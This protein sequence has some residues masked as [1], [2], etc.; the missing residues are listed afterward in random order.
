MKW[1]ISIPAWG[2]RGVDSLI[3]ICLPSVLAAEWPA[4][5]EGPPRFIVHT[6][7]ANEIAA[8][9]RGL[10]VDYRAIRAGEKYQML[11]WCHADALAVAA[12]G[13]AVMTLCADMI[14][15]REVFTACQSRF[16]SGKRAVVVGSSRTLAPDAP[17]GLPSGELLDWM[18]T[19]AHPYTQ[20]SFWGGSAMPPSTFYFREGTAIVMRGFHLHPLAVVL[21]RAVPFKGTLD[22]D[23]LQNFG[24]DEI[25]VVTDRDEMS[26]AECS[27]ADMRYNR[28]R[29]PIDASVIIPWTRRQLPLHWWLLTH[30]IKITAGECDADVPIIGALMQHAPAGVL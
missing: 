21:D 18:M 22:F 9:M 30:R 29:T 2:Q 7:R 17:A 4:Q 19:F 27:P 23:M 1:V 6:D 8:A 25:H 11:N 24:R 15:S 26:A 14:V 10:E 28:S 13:S 12:R 5:A 20:E 3:N 16:D